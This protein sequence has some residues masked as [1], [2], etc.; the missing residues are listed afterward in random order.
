MDVAIEG[1]RPARP[2]RPRRVLACRGLLRMGIAL[3]QGRGF[4]PHEPTLSVIVNERRRAGSGPARIRS[5][6]ASDSAA[7]RS[8][9]VNVAGDVSM[10]GARG[11]AHDFYCPTGNSRS[12]ATH[13]LR[14]TQAR[15]RGIAHVEPPCCRRSI[16]LDMPVSNIAP[17]KRIVEA[18]SHNPDC[19]RCWCP[20]SPRSR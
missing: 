20:C 16:D 1:P 14:S 9:T 2:G 10:R 15:T 13:V 19:W 7:T 4:V 6:D 8:F 11:E 17:M 12:R 3:R 18:R 5:V